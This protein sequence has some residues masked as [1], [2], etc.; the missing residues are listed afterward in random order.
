MSVIRGLVR[1]LSV[2][3][4]GA[5]MVA[6]LKTTPVESQ[7]AQTGNESRFLVMF[8]GIR[9]GAETVAVTR[10]DA[11]WVIS[12]TGQI[13]PPLDLT[14]TR[15]EATYGPDWQPQ[16]L[17]IEGL[18]RGQLITLSTVFQP[19]SATSD[20]LQAGQRATITHKV[21]PRTVVLPNN[22]FGAYEALAA[23]L[24]S[25]AVGTK[26]PVYVA[27]QSEVTVAVDAT[28]PRRIV[29]ANGP[30]DLQQFDLT[31]SNPSGPLKAEIWIDA[32]HRFARLVLPA[33]SVTVIRD[34][35][36]VV[37]AREERVSRPGDE[38]VF[39]PATGFNIGATVSKPPPG[40]ETGDKK[41]PAARLPAVVLV[42]GSGR[43][44]RDE[45]IHGIP[46][47]GQL[48][49]MLADA[50]FLVVRYDKRGVGV[51]GGRIESATLDDYATDVISIV[52]W[53]RRR[54]DVDADRIA[55]VGHSE[56]GAVAMLAADREDRIKA[57]GLVAA[58]GLTGREVTL[59]QQQHALT[60]SNEPE[61][62][63]KAKVALQLRIM[64]AATTG[65]G[66]EGVP[67]ALKRDADTAWFR[68]WLL[69]DPAAVMRKIDQPVLIVQGALDTQVPAAHAD[70]LE[71]LSRARKNSAAAQ[72]R[73]VVVSGVNHLLVPATTGEV[74]EYPNLPTKTVSPEIGNAIAGWLRE[75]L[76]V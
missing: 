28:R 49:G 69:F 11:G 19:T 4:L 76:K 46:I 50:G 64:E 13:A 45:M 67:P 25:A 16:R 56:G 66:W 33:A 1:H 14:T 27:P 70:R 36:S 60:R 10:T 3:L 53:L 24:S 26:F 52:S 58:P 71:T 17:A 43:Q 35:L 74:D 37:T 59:E 29:T 30:V 39:I 9:I 20:V 6:A 72:T 61:A 40:A 12:S 68:S 57:V 31:F 47:L 15:F 18:L 42:A 22:F 48:A 63:K 7:A 55:V 2:A 38:D 73:K 41:N 5:S 54:K 32:R 44:D 8:Q 62:D 34:D 21:S 51:S 23:Q 75:I 65:R